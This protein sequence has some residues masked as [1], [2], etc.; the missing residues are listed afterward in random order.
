MARTTSSP[1]SHRSFL[2]RDTT[3]FRNVAKVGDHS[4]RESASRRV[5]DIEGHARSNTN[6]LAEVV[7]AVPLLAVKP[8]PDAA[9]VT[10]SG[11]VVFAPLYSKPVHPETKLLG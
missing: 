7:V 10:S 2:C 6:S 1:Q 8:V 4:V 11:L 3:I 9:A 5:V